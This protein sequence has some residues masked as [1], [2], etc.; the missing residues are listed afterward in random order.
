MRGWFRDLGLEQTAAV[1]LLV[2]LAATWAVIREHVAPKPALT[3][4]ERAALERA[5]QAHGQACAE[6]AEH[7]DALAAAEGAE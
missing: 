2:G 4:A 1:V 5:L 6:V 7:A 3:D